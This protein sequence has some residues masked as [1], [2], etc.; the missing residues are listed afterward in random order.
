MAT[1][2]V[3]EISHYWNITQV[4]Y[5]TKPMCLQFFK[6]EFMAVHHYAP[7]IVRISRIRTQ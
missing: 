5:P 3:A 7:D 4:S 2:P 1:V 6:F